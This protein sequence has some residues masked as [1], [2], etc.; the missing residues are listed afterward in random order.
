MNICSGSH[1]KPY[2]SLNILAKK[3]SQNTQDSCTMKN[4]KIQNYMG[5]MSLKIY[6]FEICQIHH[7]PDSN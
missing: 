2:H 3:Y 4:P 5:K 6:N 1:V 7:L